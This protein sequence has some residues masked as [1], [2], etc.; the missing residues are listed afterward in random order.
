MRRLLLLLVLVRVRLRV[1]LRVGL[2]A[3]TT[4]VDLG[5]VIPLPLPLPGPGRVRRGGIL[6]GV[7]TCPGPGGG[8]PPSVPRR[9]RGR[10]G[11]AVSGRR[12]RG[13]VASI[14]LPL[15]HPPLAVPTRARG[16]G[17]GVVTGSEQVFEAAEKAG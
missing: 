12:W 6:A 7:L 2:I 8:R 5:R 16:G 17:S 14:P 15:L 4:L 13:A 1:G 9:G 3:R 11:V 10:R